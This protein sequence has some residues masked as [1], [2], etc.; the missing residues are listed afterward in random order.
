M[1][2]FRLPYTIAKE[3]WKNLEKQ[4]VPARKN[5]AGFYDE[6]FTQEE[7]DKVRGIEIIDCF[8][9]LKGISLLRNLKYLSINTKQN[10]HYTAKKNL[11]CI[12]DED[13][14]EIEKLENLE[15][16]TINNQREI[17]QI[18]ITNFKK[19]KSLEI[20]R[21]EKL[22][23]IE[24]LTE[25]RT[26]CELR[27]YELNSISGFRGLDKFIVENENLSDIELDV[28]FYPSAIKYNKDGSYNQ[29]ASKK[30]DL[31]DN[32][33][34]SES[35][36][37]KTTSINLFQIRKMHK[38]A[39]EI[40]Q[41]YC[42]FSLDAEKVVAVNEY[43]ARNITYNDDSLKSE[44]RGV[45]KDGLLIGSPRGANGA[46]DGFMFNTCV[47]EGYTRVMQYLLTLLGVKTANTH[48]VAGKDVYGFA[49]KKNDNRS[50]FIELPKDGFHS[51][52]R[53]DREHGVFYCDPCWNASRYQSGDKSMPWLLLTKEQIAET[54]TLS[55]N[56]QNF[57]NQT[58]IPKEKIEEIK[59]RITSNFLQDVEQTNI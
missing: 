14:W 54:H 36:A 59:Q 43:I 44:L 20:S 19:L 53:I 38:K 32:V 26:L 29:D 13:I 55:Y 58:P 27:L 45:S 7:L 52:C 46:Y 34:W 49:D 33:K 31:I 1:E 10:V 56:E 35:V 37:D 11:Y 28:L 4:G 15:F 42:N 23:K 39:C 48:C 47:C 57:N 21:C 50:I 18:D 2:K 41:Q 16:L 24:G 12:K 17:T 9:S 5:L 51:I 40:I 22:E 6:R 25:N 3:V 8:E 30:L